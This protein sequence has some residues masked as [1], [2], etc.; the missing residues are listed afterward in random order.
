MQPVDWRTRR[1]GFQRRSYSGSHSNRALASPAFGGCSFL[2]D[3]W[4]ER[5]S[6]VQRSPRSHSSA[7]LRSRS[8]V[9]LSSWARASLRYRIARALLMASQ[10]PR[11]R[12]RIQLPEKDLVPGSAGEPCRAAGFVFRSEPATGTLTSGLLWPGNRACAT[13]DNQQGARFGPALTPPVQASSPPLQPGGFCFWLW[14]ARQAVDSGF[15]PE[16]S[17]APPVELAAQIWRPT[18]ARAFFQGPGDDTHNQNSGFA[19]AP[20]A[21]PLNARGA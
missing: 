11:N 21:T 17:E 9:A 15:R 5:H 19:V 6:A 18:A 16:V 8:A 20:V 1:P 3:S 14:R 7:S 2:R 4:A 12:R 13:P 10:I